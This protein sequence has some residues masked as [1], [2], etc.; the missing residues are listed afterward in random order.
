MKAVIGLGSNM[1]DKEINIRAAVNSLTYLPE[2]EVLR[3]SSLYKTSPVGYKEQSF[4]INAVAEIETSLSPNALMGACL[5]I[6]AAMGRERMFENGPR[7]IDI[8][9]LIIEGFEQKSA[10][11]TVPHPR[12]RK[13]GFVLVPLR[14]LYPDGN[15]L[16]FRFDMSEADLN[17]TIVKL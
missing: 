10:E 15:A 9:I 14:E 7:K 3:V 4:F 1:D 16:G 8:D 11:L 13:R 5:G 12:M 2:S 6:E 17:D